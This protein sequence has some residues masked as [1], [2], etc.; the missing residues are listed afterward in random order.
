MYNHEWSAGVSA[1]GDSE[2]QAVIY[3]SFKRKCACTGL[4]QVKVLGAAFCSKIF[5]SVISYTL[6][7]ELSGSNAAPEN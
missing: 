6:P 3:S 7:S 5:F 2:A 4:V 1:Q